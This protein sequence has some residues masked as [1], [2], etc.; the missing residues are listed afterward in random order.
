MTK[1]ARTDKFIELLDQQEA[2]PWHTSNG[3]Y[4][5]KGCPTES[6]SCYYVHIHHLAVGYDLLRAATPSVQLRP[7]I[8]HALLVAIARERMPGMTFK[9]SNSWLDPHRIYVQECLI[10]LG[11]LLHGYKNSQLQFDELFD[12]DRLMEYKDKIDKHVY[13]PLTA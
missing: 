6:G 12:I 4:K 9:I 1:E 10:H 8:A 3:R 5:T 7:F 11:V 13:T 2:Q